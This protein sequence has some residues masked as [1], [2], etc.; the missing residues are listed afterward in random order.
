MKDLCDRTVPVW[1]GQCVQ[2]CTPNKKTMSRKTIAS[3]LI[4][5]SGMRTTDTRFRVLV[6]RSD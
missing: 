2:P 3:M 5:L 4:P 1:D 6:R